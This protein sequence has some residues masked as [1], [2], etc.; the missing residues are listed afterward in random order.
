[1][2]ERFSDRAR[3][4]MALANQEAIRLHHDYLAP[5]HLLLGILSMGSS[6]ATLVLKNL[7]IDLETLRNDANKLVKPGDK[8]LHQTKMAQRA[9][10]RQ[11]IQ[12]AIDEARKLGHKYVGTEHLLLGV[13]REGHNIPA[14]ILAERGV[15]IERLRE[16]VLS[17]L[18]SR[19]D[20]DH[21][22][23]AAG[24]DAHEWL[25]QQELAKAFRSPRFWHR[26]VY[27]VE[28]ANRLGHGEIEDEHLLLALLR[29]P[30]GFV[31]QMLAE[32]GV[33]LDW[34]RDR[35]TRATAL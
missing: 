27:A 14:Q 33:T 24:H 29:E 32:K 8:E 16:E 13:L 15:K 26:L 17:L 7:D 11:A 3:R 1:M 20:E 31:A 6:V 34:A 23:T 28:A 12:F 25:H 19:T 21:I 22:G 9:D 5:V 4:A 30:D 35:I 2:H 18:G 10:T